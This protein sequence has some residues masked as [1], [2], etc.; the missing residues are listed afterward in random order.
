MSTAP[1]EQKR[2]TAFDL[3]KVFFLL[4]II[5]HHSGV[6]GIHEC[7][8][9]GVDMFFMISGYLLYSS[10][11]RYGG[12]G[13][14]PFIKHRIG[15]LYPQ[16]FIAL[17]LTVIPFTMAGVS[18][19]YERPIGLVY[20]LL[21]IQNIGLP[22][23]GGINY[24]CWY[25]SVLMFSTILLCVV[26]KAIP[27][28]TARQIIHAVLALGLYSLLLV[29]NS[30]TIE[31]WDK[32]GN[33]VYIPLLRGLAGIAAGAFLSQVKVKWTPL[34][35][36][37]LPVMVV[38]TAAMLTNI[39]EYAILPLIGLLVCSASLGDSPLGRAGKCGLIRFLIRHEYTMYLNHAM[40]IRILALL[41]RKRV[42]PL[43][44]GIAVL[45]T[46][47]AVSVWLDRLEAAVKNK[48]RRLSRA[49]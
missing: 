16:Y 7:F 12:N 10:Y 30:A 5:I 43:V 45:I 32:L 2:N 48:R 44:F 6:I 41:L 17:M 47:T 28:K 13:L 22:Y 20:E 27:G 15:R 39:S 38:I 14:V 24:P 34:K 11:E 21:M 40:V 8:Y 19:G 25:I 31:Q 1:K 46:V 23:S 26:W 9:L 4:L 42:P 33:V 35:Y 3:L 18:L 49:P 37:D 29:N 36:L